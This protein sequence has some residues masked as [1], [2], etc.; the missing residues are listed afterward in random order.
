MAYRPTVRDRLAL[1]LYHVAYRLAPAIRDAQR[2]LARRDLIREQ[3]EAQARD[4]ARS[5][6]LIQWQQ[7]IAE[8]AQRQ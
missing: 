3:L 4:I 5:Q 7:Q 2:E 8:R 1:L 6:S